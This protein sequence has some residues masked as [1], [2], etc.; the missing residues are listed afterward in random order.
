MAE[1][2]L[3]VDMPSSAAIVA[4]IY[5]QAL[6]RL[7]QAVAAVAQQ[8]QADWVE[9]IQAARL[10]SGEKDAYAASIHWEMTGPFSAVVVSSYRY[11][12]EIESGR[13]A[14][15]LKRMLDTS[16]KV[17]VNKAGKRY[18]IIPFRHNTPGAK[19]VGQS[20]PQHV[21]KVARKLKPSSVIGKVARVSGTG[22][23]DI[24]TRM[25]LLV[26]Q[27]VYR[28]GERL[29]AG[30]MGPN[31]RGRSDRFAG[32]VRFDTTS[33]RGAKGSTYMTFRVMAEDSTGWVIPPRPGLYIVRQVVQR[34]QPL[35]ERAF[36]EAV[37][38]DLSMP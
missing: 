10:W 30:S 13:P 27:N 23:F 16:L 14:R 18:L 11:A 24:L 5:S 3:T 28:W 35:A 20:M 12:Q 31:A 19:A 26:P 7:T 8:A 38:R 17:R 22:A 9:G 32:M 15:D 2:K 6:P 36:Q 4:E 21:Y 25:P 29:E 33:P 34:L 37:R 1:F